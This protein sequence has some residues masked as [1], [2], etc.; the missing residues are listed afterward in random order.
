MGVVL[1]PL[2]FL[3]LIYAPQLLF[4]TNGNGKPFLVGGGSNGAGSGS[5]HVLEFNLSHT[6]TLLGAGGGGG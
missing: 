3:L 5:G 6:S 2:L 4:A 1:T